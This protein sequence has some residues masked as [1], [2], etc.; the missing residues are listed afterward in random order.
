MGSRSKHNVASASAWARSPRVVGEGQLE[1]AAEPLPRDLLQP[2]VL[3]T[4]LQGFFQQMHLKKKFKE[5]KVYIFRFGHL[6]T[7]K[8]KVRQH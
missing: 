6:I 2:P 8:C 1:G 4:F 3:L 5:E 7:T